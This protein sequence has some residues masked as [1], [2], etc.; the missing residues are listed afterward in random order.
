MGKSGSSDDGPWPFYEP[1]SHI[2]WM[3]YVPGAPG[4]RA[5]NFLAQ[6]VDFF[7]TIMELAGVDHTGRLDG[8][9]LVPLV[10]GQAPGAKR[11]VA[12]T[13]SQLPDSMAVRV[14]RVN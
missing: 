6:P 10:R 14:R 8:V 1:V 5:S 4:G 9:S 3:W 2:V 7:P 12:V 13:S 11:K